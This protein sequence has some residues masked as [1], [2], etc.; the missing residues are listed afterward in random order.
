MH[1]QSN[2]SRTTLQMCKGI[3][4]PDAGLKH[5][6]HDCVHNCMTGV[7]A[8]DLCTPVLQVSECRLK[9]LPAEIGDRDVYYSQRTCYDMLIEV[10]LIEAVLLVNRDYV[11]KDFDDFGGHRLDETLSCCVIHHKLVLPVYVGMFRCCTVRSSCVCMFEGR[12]ISG[13]VQARL[14]TN[15]WGAT[16]HWQGGH[17]HALSEAV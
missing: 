10:K 6:R 15:I 16:F 3:F 2:G 13:S 17:P 4:L 1:Q 7:D 11:E 14:H 9:L 5:A 8:T 12:T